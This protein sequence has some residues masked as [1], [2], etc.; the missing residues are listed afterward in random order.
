MN[1]ASP[2]SL[3]TQVLALARQGGPAQAPAAWQQAHH[4]VQQDTTP[5]GAWL[6]GVLHLLEG[7][8]EDAEYWYG[9]GDRAFRQ[10][11]T[12]VQELDALSRALAETPTAHDRPVPPDPRTPP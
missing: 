3:L 2:P 6:H 12:V 9:Q 10:R 1:T 8:L 11:G 4:L 7:D 5:L